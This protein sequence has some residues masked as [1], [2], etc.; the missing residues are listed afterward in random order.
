MILLPLLWGCQTWVAEVDFPAAPLLVDPDAPACVG[1]GTG[2]RERD[3]GEVGTPLTGT[4]D[5]DRA[6]VSVAGVGDVDAD[7]HDDI[8]VGALLY[9]GPGPDSGAAYLVRGPVSTSGT[10][11]DAHALLVGE[12]AGDLAGTSVS[13][14]GDVDADGFADLLI[15]ATEHAEGAGAAY[16]V[17]GPVDGELSLA[18]ADV[19]LV[20]ENPG[21]RAGV[22]VATAGD[23]DAD[24]Y[25]DILVAAWYSDRADEDAG[26]VYLFH[27]PVDPGDRSLA[28]ADAIVEGAGW[29]D[30][31]GRRVAG[32]GDLD[33]DGYDDIAIGA[34]YVDAAGTL[35]G[36]VYLFRGPL[37]GVLGVTEADATLHGE[38]AGDWAGFG[39]AGVGDVD[40]DGLDDLLVGAYR[41]GAGGW[42]AGAAY[43]VGWPLP[44]ESS[45]AEAK[46]KLVAEHDLGWAGIHVAAAGD[47]DGDGVR[48]VLVGSQVGAGAGTTYLV[49]GPLR[50][51]T[52][53]LHD[54]ARTTLHGEG[55]GDQAGFWVDG[56]VDLDADG[57]PDI[58][59][60][61]K[62]AD[63]TGLDAGA[64]YVVRGCP[65]R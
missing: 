24:G 25:D 53:S 8:L 34:P 37:G 65:A 42:E 64:A 56:D 19:K 51:G 58:V 44:A 18:A 62:L 11:A 23:V 54:A 63:L 29:K 49:P 16:L 22:S 35:A 27:G 13:A 21:D 5:N 15:G 4:V 12:A 39:L 10:L 2:A 36:A 26:A 6:G 38:V 31:V 3:L 1:A 47:V 40:S 41:H 43:L 17:Y 55:A 32:A 48:D 46:T 14:A 30:F 45:L 9:D 60:G 33:G 57:R 59:I 20:G 52:R 28:R 7:G 61:A 50:P